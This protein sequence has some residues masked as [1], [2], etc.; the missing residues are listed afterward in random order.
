MG[1]CVAC[2]CSE[3]N[4]HYADHHIPTNPT[5]LTGDSTLSP[6]LSP[7]PAHLLRQPWIERYLPFSTGSQLF[8]IVSP[9]R[10]KVPSKKRSNHRDNLIPNMSSLKSIY[11]YSDWDSAEKINKGKR[12]RGTRKSDFLMHHE[13]EDLKT[14]SSVGK[15]RE[16]NDFTFI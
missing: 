10:E 15:G 5:Q 16:K 11:A 13:K 8:N 3:Y 1:S 14:I 12:G 6:P 4:D 7:L 9:K 2:E